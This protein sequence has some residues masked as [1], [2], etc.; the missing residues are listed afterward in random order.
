MQYSE[1]MIRYGELSTK[2]KNRMR[3]IN[4]LKNNMEHVLSIY[5]DVSVKTDRDRGHVYLNG[6]DYHEVAESLKEI[7]GIQAFSPSFKVEKN[8][9]TLVKAVQ[10]IMTSVYKDG[11]TFKITAKRSDHSFELDSRALNHTLGDAVFS[12]LPNIKAQMKQP[13]INL[14]VEIRDEAAYISYE[15]IRGAGG[16][17]VGT[18]GKGMLMLSGGIDSP[19]AGYLALKRGVDIEAVHFASPPYTSPGALKKA[20]DLTRKL[21]KF[22][23]NIQ[24]IEVPFTEIQEEIK[25]KAPEAYL[26]TLTRRFMMRITDR[27]REDRNGLVI[28]NGESLGQVASQTL[29]SMQAINA[30]TATPIIRPVVTMDKLEIIDIAQKIDTFDISIQPFEDC[31][32]IFAPDRPKTN[33][34]IKNTEQY[35]KRMDVEGLVERAVA[36]IMVTTIQPQADSDDV[37]DLIDDLL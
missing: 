5:P 30:V 8:V 10:E 33:P 15:D 21:T 37:D 26:M 14:K 2:K 16:L 19:V 34:K 20:H 12:V 7:F 27:I 18:S 25:A 13:D 35:E 32:T 28:I 23:G 31:C 22:G 9:D 24:F 4:K 36:G 6:T 17:P 29:E 1:I 3:F 11:M